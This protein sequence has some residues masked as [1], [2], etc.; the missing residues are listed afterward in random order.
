MKRRVPFWL[1]LVFISVLSTLIFAE[2]AGG[3][4]TQEDPWQVETAE[5]LNNVRNYLGSGHRNKHFIQT[6][7]INLG[8]PPWNQG[9]GWEPIGDIVYSP[10]NE[11]PFRGVYDGDGHVIWRLFIDRPDG[12]HQGLFG[13]AEGNIRNLCVVDFEVMAY[14][15]VGGLAGLNNGRITNCFSTGSVNGNMKVAALL[16]VNGGNGNISNS[17]SA[18]NVVGVHL[19]GGLVGE[20]YGIIS[21]SYSEGSVSGQGNTGG[22]VGENYQADI[23][24]C[25]SKAEVSGTFCTGGLV[26]INFNGYMENCYS[27]GSVTGGAHY[28][29][30][31]NGGSDVNITGS[32]WNTQTSGQT[33]SYGGEGRLTAQ[34]VFPHSDDTYVD[35]D[36]EIW[37]P[38]VDHVINDGYP[39]LRAFH[40][41][42]GV[43]DPVPPIVGS[44][45]SAFPQ[46]AFR[47]PTISIK[48]ES[49]GKLSYSIYN[50]R[51]QKVYSA[52][53]LG[54]EKEQ[55]FE[56]PDEA[57]KRLSNGVFLLTLERDKHRIA[58]S[59]MVV[60]K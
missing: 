39:Y 24:N 5:H 45:I 34:M 23:V 21:G 37:A 4:G 7:D 54:F 31:L 22:L 14:D 18:G 16:G 41:D 2:F 3:S 53:I 38:D 9:E 36:W 33:S 30:G 25:Y 49:P 19:V 58:T 44:S 57:W 35:W 32:Y 28:T 43:D 15:A 48:S 6:A 1:A 29:G 8:E 56:L 46:P 59:R 51:G 20:N 55:S 47:A 26:G 13:Y 40:G 27:I 52:E 42:V 12:H 11:N 17:R 60:T 50:V 10:N